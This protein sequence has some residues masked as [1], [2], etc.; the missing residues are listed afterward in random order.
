MN[1][2]VVAKP[3]QVGNTNIDAYD[4]DV[5][6]DHDCIL[7]FTVE[8][9]GEVRFWGLRVEGTPYE[10]DLAHGQEMSPDSELA[11]LLQSAAK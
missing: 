2:K 9:D 6:L 4:L 8:S 11:K 5:E 1:V 10:G 3:V 7:E